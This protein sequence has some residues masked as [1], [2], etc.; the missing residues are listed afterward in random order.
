MAAYAD[1]IFTACHYRGFNT[2]SFDMRRFD[3]LVNG[4]LKSDSHGKGYYSF[5]NTVTGLALRQ[6]FIDKAK[7]NPGLLSL[8]L[9]YMV[10]MK[11]FQKMIKKV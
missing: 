3:L 6:Y 7:Y 5:I 9:H 8:I 1:D 2:T 10:L 4:D 11:E